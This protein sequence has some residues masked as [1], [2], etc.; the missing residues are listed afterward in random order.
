VS[1]FIYL[2]TEQKCTGRCKWP[3]IFH[4]IKIHL[5]FLANEIVANDE[6]TFR[7]VYMSKYV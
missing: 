7:V 6:P 5:N 1:V 2:K 4:K 3:K